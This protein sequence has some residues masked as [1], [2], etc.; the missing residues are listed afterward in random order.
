MSK[1]ITI[2]FKAAGLKSLWVPSPAAAPGA[3]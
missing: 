1:N 2:P 3:C